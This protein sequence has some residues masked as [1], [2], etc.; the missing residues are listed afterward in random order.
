MKEMVTKAIAEA[1]LLVSAIY[2]VAAVVVLVDMRYSIVLPNLF[3]TLVIFC[4]VASPF[5]SL[6][7][8]SGTVA[9]LQWPK[10][11]W[12]RRTI[13]AINCLGTIVIGALGGGMGLTVSR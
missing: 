5:A 7:T 4:L 9:S 1:G 6:L 3:R 2:A 11:G 8:V 13:C 10:S 12:R